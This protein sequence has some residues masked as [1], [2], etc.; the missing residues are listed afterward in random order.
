MMLWRPFALGI[1]T[2]QISRGYQEKDNNDYEGGAEGDGAKAA[3]RAVRVAGAGRSDD[4]S[5][6]KGSLF[7][8]SVVG[9]I[10]GRWECGKVSL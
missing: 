2:W 9:H 6:D 8:R 3:D 1:I 5:G 10:W 7:G 4:D